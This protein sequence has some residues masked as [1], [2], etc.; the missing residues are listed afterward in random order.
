MRIGYT[1]ISLTVL[2]QISTVMLITL[3]YLL[4]VLKHR[5]KFIEDM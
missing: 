1:M 4:V 5:I 3:I 2:T